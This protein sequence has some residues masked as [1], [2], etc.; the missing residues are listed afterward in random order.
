[1]TSVIGLVVVV[2]FF[3]SC[4]LYMWT[5]GRE[6]IYWIAKDRRARMVESPDNNYM[7]IVQRI[8]LAS[9]DWFDDDVDWDDTGIIE[10]NTKEDARKK[11]KAWID[12]FADVPG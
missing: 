10:G 3:G 2:L 5:A 8:D 12:S 1:M 4:L 7:L 9:V 11:A 6:K